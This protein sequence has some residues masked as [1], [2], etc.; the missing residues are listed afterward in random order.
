MGGEMAPQQPV[1][2]DC[3]S[4]DEQVEKR[5][6]DEAELVRVAVAIELVGDE[7]AEDDEAR[8]ISPELL[9]EQ[10]DHQRPFHQSVAEQV[11]S[12]EMMGLRREA[13][14][15]PEHVP[16]QEIVRVF[17]ELASR[18]A[19]DQADDLADRILRV[20][21]AD[22][23]GGTTAAAGTSAPAVPSQTSSQ[24]ATVTVLPVHRRWGWA[25]LSTAEQERFAE[26]EI[27]IHR[28][29]AKLAADEDYCGNPPDWTPALSLETA[30]PAHDR[31][32]C[33]S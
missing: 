9:T 4:D 28:L 26:L 32:A 18:E 19:V 24:G 23:A 10:P 7:G 3:E 12:V 14:R 20:V 16:G 27:S 13:F 11:E 33:P 15:E 2:V 25:A 1:L 17:D 22:T 29:R 30:V 5:Q 8:G 21:A 6:E 31:L